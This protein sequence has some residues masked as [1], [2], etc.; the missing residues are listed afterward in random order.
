MINKENILRCKLALY[1]EILNAKKTNELTSTEINL[2]Y[3]LCL[4]KQVQAHI[5]ENGF[6]NKMQKKP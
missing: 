4:D 5:D 2:G 3:L 1:R 6:S